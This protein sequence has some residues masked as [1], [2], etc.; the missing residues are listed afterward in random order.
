MRGDYDYLRSTFADFAK[1]SL[2][3]RHR[4]PLSRHSGQ[5]FVSAIALVFAAFVVV[6]VQRYGCGSFAKPVGR[7]PPGP[8]VI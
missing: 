1:A 3:H 4:S 2:H 6:D 7:K 5:L 8:E